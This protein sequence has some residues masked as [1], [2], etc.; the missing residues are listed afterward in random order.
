MD[1]KLSDVYYDKCAELGLNDIRTLE[2][3]DEET[4]EEIGIKS[5]VHR[6]M[7]LKQIQKF[8]KD[9]K[10][11]KSFLR[12]STYYLDVHTVWRMVGID[13]NDGI[14]RYFGRAWNF[15]I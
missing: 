5:K 14:W 11:V 4:M 12:L 15:D 1:K 2:Y 6:K 13:C 10:R 8:Q 7:F 9:T 3:L